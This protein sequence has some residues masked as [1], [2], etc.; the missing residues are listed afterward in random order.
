MLLCG[1]ATKGKDSSEKPATDFQ[2]RQQCWAIVPV[3]RLKPAGAVVL[4]IYITGSRMFTAPRGPRKKMRDNST[5]VWNVEICMRELQVGRL[6][7]SLRV[8]VCLFLGMG[9]GQNVVV[10]TLSRQ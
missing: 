6:Q 7:V 10:F 1:P 9:G 2:L 4:Y 3:A 8:F 5:G